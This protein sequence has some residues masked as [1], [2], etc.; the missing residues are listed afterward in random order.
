MSQIIKS[1][2][3]NSQGLS[4]EAKRIAQ[5]QLSPCLRNIDDQTLR[6]F[7]GGLLMEAATRLG[8]KQLSEEIAKVAVQD[9]ERYLREDCTFWSLEE[10]SMALR[11]GALGN[12]G[13]REE[14]ALSSRV[15][16]SWIKAFKNGPRKE[17]VHEIRQKREK[18]EIE[19]AREAAEKNDIENIPA[20]MDLFFELHRTSNVIYIAPH[21]H[22]MRVG[23]FKK[24]NEQR[25]SLIDRAMVELKSEI[26]KKKNVM[27]RDEYRRI[28]TALSKVVPGDLE[29]VGKEIVR[30]CRMIELREFYRE[31]LRDNVLPSQRIQSLKQANNETK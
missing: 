19:A 28:D 18:I 23:L 17:A 11:E 22:G 5:A 8:Q 27:D 4:L 1:M 9:L 2:I 26:L 31:C 21:I 14:V 16:I 24:T 25:W 10:V 15:V 6:R 7:I 20:M 30:R 3:A 13:T 29:S 12:L